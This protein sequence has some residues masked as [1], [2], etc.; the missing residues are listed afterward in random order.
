M[1]VDLNKITMS[2]PFGNIGQ[3]RKIGIVPRYATRKDVCTNETNLL[4]DISDTTPY[5]TCNNALDINWIENLK[6]SITNNATKV[7]D[8]TISYV[9]SDVF[10]SA[11]LND[12]TTY[13]D[14]YAV[15]ANLYAQYTC[16]QSQDEIEKKHN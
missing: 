11:A 4:T 15:R 13:G 5:T 9:L 3:V 14:C 6:N 8:I 16:E 2:C 1:P 7:R 10:S 12:S